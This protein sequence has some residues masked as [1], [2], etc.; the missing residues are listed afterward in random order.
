M[1]KFLSV[2]ML[3]LLSSGLAMASVS[4]PQKKDVNEETTLFYCD[5][6]ETNEIPNLFYAK[7]YD[8]NTP[9]DDMKAI[10]FESKNVAWFYV[11]RDTQQSENVFCGSTSKYNPAGS[12]D[13]WLVSK[14]AIAI[15]TTGYILRWK[16]QA[17]NPDRRD[18]LKVFISTKGPN[19][20][21][22]FTDKPVFEV[23]EEE[24]GPTAATDNEW[25]EH[26]I[27]LDDY[28][29]K[30]IWFAF[31]NQSYDKEIICIDDIVVELNADWVLSMD[32]EKYYTD[33]SVALKGK[34]TAR[35]KELNS[36]T[37]AYS[38]NGGEEHAQTYNDLALKVGESHDFEFTDK[39][40]LNKG[41]LNEYTI[42]LIVDGQQVMTYTSSIG[43]LA[44]LPKRKIVLEEG[45]GIWCGACP[46]GIVAIE[47]LLENYPGE[48]IPIAIHADADPWAINAYIKQLGFSVLPSGFINRAEY[49]K[50]TVDGTETDANGN[51]LQTFD[52]EGTFLTT[53]LKHREKPTLA[54]IEI[55]GAEYIGRDPEEDNRLKL[56]MSTSVKFAVDA[57]D[58]D[59][60]ISF[61]VLEDSL[62]SMQTNYM[63]N[64]EDPIYGEFGKGGKYGQSSIR[65]YTYVDV[66]RLIT[67]TNN[68][69]NGDAGSV[70]SSVKTD[71]EYPYDYTITYPS[72]MKEY[73]NLKLVALLID[74]K[75]GEI[76]NADIKKIDESTGIE[77]VEAETS[78]KV[79][80]A[81]RT[82]HVAGE[83]ESMV[84]TDLSGKIVKRVALT[85]SE[86]N[87]ADLAAGIYVVTLTTAD[88][89]RAVAKV[90]L[91]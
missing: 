64:S 91:K 58:L 23:T 52:G 51:K 72:K 11:L 20:K 61:V 45:T 16:S 43:R 59:Y 67:P 57:E 77:G 79:W 33:E 60:R 19:F 65:N 66:A 24:A 2:F 8:N 22:D 78:A 30:D 12:A 39:M 3:S 5:F 10:G 9:A 53:F 56:Q 76:M 27:P 32:M 85:S 54:S 75:T 42:R 48:I 86:V 38:A 71:V 28:A 49:C 63:A 90:C 82:L 7:S 18:G 13:D 15:P 26:S 50:P 47:H 1:G 74:N 4:V 70:P 40:T 69:F 35:A 6:Q 89:N 87:V 81:G 55:T 25:V 31:V 41:N 68:S 73:D 21:E 17:S 34:V 62:K 83:A 29:G 80:A 46:G 44:Y 36:Y 88:Q 14:N 37:V 84:I